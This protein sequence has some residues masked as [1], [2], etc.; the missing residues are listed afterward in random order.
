MEREQR[1]EHGG[2]ALLVFVL[3]L[4]GAA[5]LE[6]AIASLSD[7]HPRRRVVRV[8]LFATAASLV[9]CAL[10]N[11]GA[12]LALGLALAGAACGVA[13]GA[14]QAELV[15]ATPGDGARAMTRW[16]LLGGVGDVL[17]PLLVALI[18][19][20][21][22]TYRA[23]FLAAAATA[24]LHALLIPPRPP[25]SASDSDADSDLPD[26]D[27]DSVPLL[28]ALRQALRNRQLWFW[29]LGASLCT[30]LDELVVAL[31]A[32]RAET[33]L[34]AT[35]AAAVVC[36][37]GVSVGGVLGAWLTERLL[38]TLS[39]E[40]VLLASASAALGSLLAV[41]LA[42]DVAWLCVALVALGASAAPQYA[43]LKARAYAA[44]PGHPGVVNAL[45]Q[46]F[47]VVDI[48][49]PLALGVVADAHGVAV[50]LAGLAVQPL[51]VLVVLLGSAWRARR[52]REA[53]ASGAAQ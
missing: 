52:H 18:L 6:A 47:V 10:A 20:I 37:T 51:G 3:P 45:A 19:A 41:V 36:V 22:G 53:A 50:A 15:A 21:G 27:S 32:L 35:P 26:S 43:L 48:A 28:P 34:G 1:V 42:P 8:A 25:N 7:R 24:L 38:G 29:L 23:A 31:A 30:F 14:A 11:Q 46:A 5:L 4:L 2:Y 33:E 9:L 16:V 12:L 13:C 17:T 49:G 44:S 39:S 40:R